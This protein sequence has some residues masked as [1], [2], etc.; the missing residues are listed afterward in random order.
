MHRSAASRTPEHGTTAEQTAYRYLFDA[1]S[2]GRFATGQRI[3]AETIAAEL[4]MSR[5]P[6]REALR[7]LHAEGLVVLRPNRGAIV[8][9]LSAEE[10]EDIFD[11]RV[12]LESLA[13]RVAAPRCTDEHLRTLARLLDDMDTSVGDT[14]LWVQRH[15]AF[16]EYLCGISGRTRLYEQIRSL[17]ALIEGAMRLWIEQATFRRKSARDYHQL[18]IDALRS[19]DPE[20]AEQAMR[21]HIE[22]T[23]PRV[24]TLLGSP[25]PRD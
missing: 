5:M 21:E 16:H 3:V 6:V 4:S 2:Q 7:R 25:K 15:C 11:M 18:L 9:G 14:D 20:L 8:R 17:Y 13:M 12:A 22:S 24:L 19:R 10:L 1:I 23:V